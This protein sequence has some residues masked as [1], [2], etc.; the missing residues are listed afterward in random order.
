MKKVF[1]SLIGI[2]RRRPIVSACVGLAVLA[3]FFL[4]KPSGDSSED[5][6]YHTVKRNDFL[7][8]ITE[9]GAVQAVNE[10]EVRNEL[11]GSSRIISI[12]KEGSFV[13][14]GDLIVELDAGEAEDALN[15]QQITYEKSVAEHVAAENNLIIT[16]STAESATKTAELNLLLA[17]M[18]LQKFEQLEKVQLVRLADIDILTEQEALQIA[19]EKLRYSKILTEKGFETKAKLATDALAVTSASARL[20]EMQSKQKMLTDYDL[21]IQQE[22]FSAAVS[23]ARREMERVKKQGESEIA[24]AVADLNAALRT[25]ELNKSKL[26]KMTTQFEATKVRAPID[27]LVVYAIE[28]S[29]NSSE[30]MIEEGATVRQRQALIKIPDTSQMK[31]V[32]KVDE[33]HISQV[34]E[35]QP[36]FVVLDSMPDQNFRGKVTKVGLLPDAGDR[37]GGSGTKKYAT[38]ILITDQLPEGVKP[39]VSARAE[40]VITNLENVLTVPIQAVT[41]VKGKQLVYLR[42]LGGAEPSEVEIGLFNNKFIEITKG[43]KEGDEVLLSPPLEPD[44][45]FAGA[46]AEGVDDHSDLPTAR[47]EARK[48]PVAPVEG[49]DADGGGRGR[50]GAPPGA[51]K[52]GAGK[53][54][55][56]EGRPRGD[57]AGGA[58]GGERRQRG[59]GAGGAGG[60]GGE[61]GGAGAKA[62][63]GEAKSGA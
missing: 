9:G 29:R 2:L 19:N 57:G 55:A 46:I 1:T 10:V 52:P 39:E 14:A 23:E 4:L 45:D 47:P 21:S 8:S 24:Q 27:G 5:S 58:A 30:S 37:W 7:V 60:A 53:P 15:Q 35:G 38:E 12:V 50:P 20:E 41:T 32:V 48:M 16:K 51:G 54:G 63:G 49:A 28:R 17:D 13:K 26:D 25:L 56:G 3:A 33:S 62:A 31:V 43:V 42:R 22:T 36:A 44:G 59:G 61:S 40:I 34:R 6:A 18:A 11:E